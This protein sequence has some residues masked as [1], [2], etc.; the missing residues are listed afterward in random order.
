[1]LIAV[2]GLALTAAA[3]DTGI[4]DTLYY[5]DDGQAY[6]YP[7]GAFRIPIYIT[8]DQHIIGLSYGIEYG[9]GGYIEPVWDSLTDYGTIFDEGDYL[10]MGHLLYSN[11][12]INGIAPDTVCVGGVGINNPLPPGKYKYC[13]VWFSSGDIGEQLLVDTAFAEPTCRLAFIENGVGEYTPQCVGGLLTIVQGIADLTLTLPDDQTVNAGETITFDVSAVS[14]YPPATVVFDSLV[15]TTGEHEP[16]HS[17]VTYGDN[18]LTFEWETI[19]YEGG[20]EWLAHFTTTDG[21][22]TPV[23]GAVPITVLDLGP[24]YGLI[25]DSDCSGIID[26]DDV[27]F[28]VNFIFGGGPVPQCDK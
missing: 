24:Y 16:Y 5:G 23:S 20:T 1:M 3:E 27:V 25:G 28:L 7:D 22:S 21:V 10:E 14:Y 2:A 12:S 26:I 8:S 17:P 9:L 13:D 11:A 6:G 19:P 15:Q 18:P 4:P